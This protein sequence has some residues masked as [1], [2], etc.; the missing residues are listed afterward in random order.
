MKKLIELMCKGEE[1]TA[2]FTTFEKV[3]YG[4][5]LPLGLIALMGLAGWMESSF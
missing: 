4:I 1:N 5:L 2:P 3:F